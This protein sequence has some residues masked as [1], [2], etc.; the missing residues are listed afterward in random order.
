MDHESFLK[1]EYGWDDVFDDENFYNDDEF[2]K[3]LN[4]TKKNLESLS[5]NRNESASSEDNSANE[6]FKFSKVLEGIKNKLPENSEER[7]GSALSADSNADTEFMKFLGGVKSELSKLPEE[8][9]AKSA[10]S[11]LKKNSAA[12]EIQQ[13]QSTTSEVQDTSNN[14][15]IDEKRA[16]SLHMLQKIENKLR[17]NF[18]EKRVV[19]AKK[20]YKV[21]NENIF[22][23]KLPEDMELEWSVDLRTTAGKTQGIKKGGCFI[24]CKI[25]LASKV[26]TSF[27]RLRDTLL[28][29]M[30]HAAVFLI[31]QVPGENHGPLWKAWAVRCSLVFPY[32]EMP[33]RCHSYDLS[34]PYYYQCKNCEWKCGRHRKSTKLSEAC[35]P[36]CRSSLSL[37]K[38]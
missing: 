21:F 13:S 32:I 27:E 36:K 9:R 25:I 12:C 11:L 2:N 26:L 18:V 37:V 8:S 34:Y 31:S 33:Q 35:C 28:H 14:H 4:R 29:E 20:L 15:C 7:N 5:L 17:N 23:S 16:S 10:S 3:F 38:S 30:C 6:K 19:G 24:R 1:D 22:D